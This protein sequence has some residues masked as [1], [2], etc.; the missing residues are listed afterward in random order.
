MKLSRSAAAAI[1]VAIVAASAFGIA[2]PASAAT[3]GVTYVH[4]AD[5]G[6]SSTPF[7]AP[8]WSQSSAVALTSS[9][10]GLFL[11]NNARPR[12]GFAP[13]DLTSGTALTDFAAASDYFA[14]VDTLQTEILWYTDTAH[15]ALNSMYS[16]AVGSAAFTDP[17]AVWRANLAV[18]TIPA[19]TPTTLALLDIQFGLNSLPEA[20]ATSVDLI[21]F[22]V[23]TDLYGFVVNSERFSFMPTPVVTG[24][25]ATITQA[26][27]GSTGWNLTASGFLPNETVS[28]FASSPNGGGGLPDV[29]ADAN[30]VAT[31]SWVGTTTEE[32][33]AYEVTLVG[34]DASQ[35]DQRFSFS[36][37]AALPNM[38]VETTLPIIAASALLLGGAALAIVA[39]KRRKR[40]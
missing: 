3:P 15:T 14:S 2:A 32:L 17:A 18:G 13:I 22:G 20:N 6:P 38:G 19:N 40:A 9:I 23:D 16:N 26:A 4:A 10:N 7:D 21:N 35:V 24:A 8:G 29:I 37:V 34:L 31:F 5:V 33:G 39:S 30:G 25:P 11:G 28:V 1:G 12:Y 27:F 36:V